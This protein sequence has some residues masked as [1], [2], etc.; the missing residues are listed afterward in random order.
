MIYFL[1]VFFLYPQC[2]VEFWVHVSFSVNMCDVS[3]CSDFSI[4]KS[5]LIIQGHFFWEQIQ[6]GYK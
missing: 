4:S 3:R 6:T 2:F 5:W 1:N